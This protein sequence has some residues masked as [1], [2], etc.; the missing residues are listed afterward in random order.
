MIMVNSKNNLRRNQTLKSI[1]NFGKNICPAFLSVPNYS[2]IELGNLTSVSSSEDPFIDEPPPKYTPRKGWRKGIVWAAS[3]A[4]FVLVLN[5]LFLAISLTKYD[6]PDGIGTLFT[7]SCAKAAHMDSGMYK[8][9]AE[10]LNDLGV[11]GSYDEA[12]EIVS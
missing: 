9:L 8:S 7:G 12:P 2:S 10:Y 1:K 4:V 11:F 6:A 3:V 5:V